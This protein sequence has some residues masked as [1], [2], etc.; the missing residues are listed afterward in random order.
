[1]CIDYL[2][3]VTI[4]LCLPVQ[5]SYVISLKSLH[6][7]HAVSIAAEDVGWK[8]PA[9][10]SSRVRVRSKADA[11]STGETAPPLARAGGRGHP[12]GEMTNAT[13][14]DRRLSKPVDQEQGPRSRAIIPDQ[15]ALPPPG[16]PHPHRPGRRP[17]HA[18]R[19]TGCRT[20]PA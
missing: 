15:R 4:V 5:E 17:A 1:M 3:R 10:R 8:E 2:L 13:P 12:A 6:G 9:P 18:G 19:G 14:D 16:A 20:R 11:F 7:P